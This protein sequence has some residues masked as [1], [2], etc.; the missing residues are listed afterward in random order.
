MKTIG[1]DA[2]SVRLKAGEHIV[3]EL[4]AMPTA[5]YQW[6]LGEHPGLEV[7]PLGYGP[8]PPGVGGS[9]VERFEV[10]APRA[11]Q[12]RLNAVYKR[13]WESTPERTA[14]FDIAVA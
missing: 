5:G 1:I 8:P 2:R 3:I 11:G 9:T 10:V 4:P 12:F 7:K 14:Q 6:S 13:Q